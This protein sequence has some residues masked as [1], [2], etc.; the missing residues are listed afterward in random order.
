MPST[1][2]T[3]K[4][5]ERLACFPDDIQQ[6]DL[7]TYF[8]L[9]EHD[10]SLI[11]TYQGESNR[12]GAALQL[13][14]VRYLGFCPA[15][16]HTA[17][18]DMTAFLARQL[19]V[20]PSVLQ[21][22]GKR[23]MTRN[24]HF[25]AV[26]NHLGFRRVQI[27][28][29]EQIVAWLTERALEHDKP[30]L[31]FQ[32]ICERLK[33]QQMIRPAVT[34]LERWVVTAR[35]Q[36]HHESLRRLQ[37]LLTPERV[38]LLDSLL[39]T[40]EDKGKTQLYQFRQPAISNTP[41]ALLSPLGKLVTLQSWSVDAW[42]M[43]ALNPNRQKFL[44][45]LGRKYTVQALRRMGP[46]RRYPILLSFLKQTLIDLTDE[47]IDIFDV[48]I[49]SRHKKARKALQEYQTA[50]AET[51]EAHSQLLQTIGDL[52]LDDTVTDD[53]LRQAIY[54]HIPRSNLQMAVKEAHALRRPN[55]YF[56][57]LDDHYSYVRQFAPQFLETL[58]FESHE[59]DDTLLEA[60]EVF[61]SLNT[62]KRRK[63]PE[64]VPVDFVPD[65][66][67]RFVAPEG[68]PERR[69]Y[70]LC[71]LSTRRDK[72]RSGDIY[73]PNSR[74]YTDPE[75]FLI[76]RS[77]W[78]D[79]RTDVCQQLD[80]DPTGKA[81]L[82]ERAQE[83]K[84][85]LPR[86]DRVLDRSDGIRIEEGELIVPMDEGED[87]PEGVQALDDQIHRRIPDVDLTDLLLEVDQ[88]TGFSQYLTHA[89][90]GQPRTDDLVLH[91]HAA[92][93]GQGTNM[94]L[95][96]MAHSAGLA[97]DRL[98]WA[99]TWYLREETLKAAVATLVN[100]QYRQPLAQHWGG[101]TLSSSDGQRCP[102]QGKVRNARALPRYFGYGEGMT[103]YTWSSDQ[104]SQYGTK[105]ISST[106]RDATYVLD[107]ILNNETD[108]TILEHTTDTAGYT[109]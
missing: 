44:A 70:E 64:D 27:E 100:F 98:A 40:E 43:S 14:A 84:D 21:D 42:E 31:L 103:F 59:E 89:G 87:L 81:R 101:G 82:S 57:F 80:L 79:L 65:N 12:L 17:S 55:S 35:M 11:D 8:T 45:R 88:W 68:H 62:T 76:P 75:T 7:I 32:M 73:L 48:C 6:W 38:T 95:I 28:D 54:H 51:T 94:G 39:I 33:Q 10:C 61:R 60:I 41:T 58:S 26:L 104:F 74:R 49:A 15:N 1:F 4:E 69:A 106:V 71:T 96:E 93:V 77:E 56:D 47:S 99:S 78:P 36:A 9:T 102:V 108:L 37:P 5:Q 18:S 22:Y 107:E 29:H 97:Y 34:T 3:C 72:L 67:Q 24:V 63:L 13:C 53:N 19:K 16:L 92:I 66:W 25:N 20:D 52:V 105:V 85:L 83:L 46:E 91:Q 2:L 109:D 86:V 23:R 90:G 50:I 30:T